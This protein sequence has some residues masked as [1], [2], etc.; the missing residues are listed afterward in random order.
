MNIDYQEMLRRL[1]NE[2]IPLEGAVPVNV[3][4][5]M[6]YLKRLA[7]SALYKERELNALARASDR[8]SRAIR[9]LM[10]EVARLGKTMGKSGYE[11]PQEVDPAKFSNFDIRPISTPEE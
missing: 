1:A 6:V 3:V 11:N 5:P 7:E 2:G 4:I 8:Q 10:T 9:Q